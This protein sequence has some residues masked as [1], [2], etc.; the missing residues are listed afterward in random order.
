M[1]KEFLNPDGVHKPTGYSH[2][3]RVGNLIFVAGQV[4]VD[5]SGNLI[6][7]GD[8]AAQAEQVFRNLER[9]LA[10]CGARMADIVK[11]NVFLTDARHLPALREVRQRYLSDHTPTSTVVQVVAL[12]RPELL[13]EIEVV[14]AV[15]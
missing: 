1:A 2:A 12:A 14:A 11:M 5:E 9:V 8:A 3:A 15:D 6:G 7:P 13:M 10:G 4:S